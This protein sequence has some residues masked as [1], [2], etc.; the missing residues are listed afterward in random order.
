MKH[1]VPKMEASE[2]VFC[3]TE[4]HRREEKILIIIQL[5]SKE[6]SARQLL[7]QALMVLSFCWRWEEQEALMLFRAETVSCACQS[8]IVALMAGTGSGLSHWHWP[9]ERST[10]HP[11]EHQMFLETSAKTSCVESL[12][13][14]HW[15]DAQLS[16]K[17]ISC[18][19]GC[20]DLGFITTVWFFNLLHL[21][22][23]EHIL[24]IAVAISTLR[25]HSLVGTETMM[26]PWGPKGR[27]GISAA[28]PGPRGAAPCLPLRNY[29]LLLQF[30]T[31]GH[32]WGVI[33]MWDFGDLMGV[34]VTCKRC[35]RFTDFNPIIFEK[36]AAHTNVYINHRGAHN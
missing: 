16:K 31:L 35:S 12:C 34:S 17:G 28:V 32:Y 4:S 9:A 23:A 19:T 25:H 21:Q 22:A 18:E 11:R 3:W 29:I 13:Y 30:H 36:Y 20:R 27:W 1:K 7:L 33:C 10:F 14:S 24:L 6:I 8:W 26:C 15:A 2:A 5:L